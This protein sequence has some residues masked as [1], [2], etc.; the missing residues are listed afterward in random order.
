MA[1]TVHHG[2]CIAVAVFYAWLSPCPACGCHHALCMAVLCTAVL[3]HGHHPLTLSLQGAIR[4]EVPQDC[5]EY[6]NREL[7][8]RKGRS[9]HQRGSPRAPQSPVPLHRSRQQPPKVSPG[10]V[11]EDTEARG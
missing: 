11:G 6:D 7:G 3:V 10:M 4:A 8:G 1:V 5:L 9:Q 2:P